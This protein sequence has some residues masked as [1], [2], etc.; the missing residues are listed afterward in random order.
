MASQYRLQIVHE[1]TGQVVVSWPAGVNR[2]KERDF[3]EAVCER[4][5]EKGVGVGRTEA[6][7]IADVREAL[8]DVIG[9]AKRRV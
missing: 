2:P 8:Q 9:E 4:V 3:I 7:V 5:R 1:P 6:H